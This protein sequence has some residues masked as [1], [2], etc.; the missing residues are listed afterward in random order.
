LDQAA[1]ATGAKL[2][3]NNSATSIATIGQLKK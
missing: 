1:A 2:L 3:R